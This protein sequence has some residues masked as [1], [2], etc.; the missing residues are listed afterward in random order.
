MGPGSQASPPGD[1]GHDPGFLASLPSS[2][3]LDALWGREVIQLEGFFNLDGFMGGIVQLMICFEKIYI[4]IYV[5]WGILLQLITFEQKYALW[6]Y[7]YSS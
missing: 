4:Y 2:R 3:C 7:N 6:G 5:C 1:H